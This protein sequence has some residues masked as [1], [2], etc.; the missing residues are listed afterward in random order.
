MRLREVAEVSNSIRVLEHKAPFQC[1]HPLFEAGRGEA[2]LALEEQGAQGMA[3]QANPSLSS[4]SPLDLT[5]TKGNE[6]GICAFLPF[7]PFP[8]RP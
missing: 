3:H 8:D 2:S 7:A 6:G 4:S 5:F 1:F